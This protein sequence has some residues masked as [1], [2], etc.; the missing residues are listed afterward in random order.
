[1]IR[2]IIKVEYLDKYTQARGENFIT[3]D[4]DVKVLESLLKSGGKGE[5]CYLIHKL[6]GCEVIDKSPAIT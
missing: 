4:D 5:D 6:V 2:F 3:I 1:M